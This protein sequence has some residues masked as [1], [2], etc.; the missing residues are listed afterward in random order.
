MNTEEKETLSPDTSIEAERIQFEIWR[1]M[2]A[3]RKM[4]L[5]CEM[6]A[7]VKSLAHAGLAKRF[8]EATAEELDRRLKDLMLGPDLAARVYGPPPYD[9]GDD[10]H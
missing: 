4:E 2:P 8:P 9:K 3:W 6:Y 1:E 7:T 10:G 5:V